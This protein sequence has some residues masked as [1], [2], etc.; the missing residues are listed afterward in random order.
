MPSRE[1][2][3]DRNY[4]ADMLLETA[5]CS[6]HLL[7]HANPTA[8]AQPWACHACAVGAAF[9]PLVSLHVGPHMKHIRPITF[10]QVFTR[11]PLVEAHCYGIGR[12]GKILEQSH[13]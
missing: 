8:H 9:N 1:R 5:S 13:I 6:W 10:A 3:E 11:V 12:T 4:K 7:A 2:E